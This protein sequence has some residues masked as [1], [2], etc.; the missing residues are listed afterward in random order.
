MQLDTAQKAKVLVFDDDK[1]MRASLE[2]LLASAGFE[3]I[4]AASALQ[5]EELIQ[6]HLPDAVLTDVRMPGR[7][8]I[9]L[10]QSLNVAQSPPVI[11][12]SAHADIPMAVDAMQMGA[13]TFLE[14]PF[15]PRRLVS[16]LKHASDQFQLSKMTERLKSRLADLSGLN[17]IYLGNSKAAQDLRERV[18]NLAEVDVP[19]LIFG[20][21]GTGKDLIARALHDLSS[22][23]DQIFG[24]INCAT[25]PVQE[26]EAL[27]F[28]RKGESAGWLKSVDG[29]TLFLDEVHAAPLEVQAKLS[30]VLEEKRFMPLGADS[31]ESVSFRLISSL[32]EEP[33]ELVRNGRL[34]EE[35]LYRIQRLELILPPLRDRKEDIPILFEHFL[36]DMARS[37][38]MPPPALTSEDFAALLAHDWPGNVRE[39]RSTAERFLFS[40]RMGGGELA[41]LLA[42]NS[43]QPGAPNTLRGA[44]A[45]FEKTLLVRAIQTHEGRMDDAAAALGIGRRTL[46]EKMVKLGLNRD[47]IL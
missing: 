13:Y 42:H 23:S 20:E 4:M 12:V 25:I 38:E 15:D 44:V 46:N 36:G 1:G 9:D 31:D 47:Q 21:T 3:P 19:I 24:A 17:R 34:R 5:A 41:H 27:M 22:K 18:I 7:S 39:L 28:G 32:S 43:T 33:G 37:F 14:K 10:L 45:A 29:G 11:L 2:D 16:V 30:R 26:F 35:F 8:G 6:H 40:T